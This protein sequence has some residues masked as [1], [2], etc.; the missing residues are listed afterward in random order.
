MTILADAMPTGRYN[1]IERACGEENGEKGWEALSLC[2][3]KQAT[4]KT[5]TY[6]SIA[7]IYI[8]LPIVSGVLTARYI[9]PRDYSGGLGR[10]TE[11]WWAC[12]CCSWLP[13]GGY[14]TYRHGI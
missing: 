8:G 4:R 7:H 10:S 11:R 2:S 13:R 9:I 5:R 1:E 14:Q 3:G 12:K 6:Q